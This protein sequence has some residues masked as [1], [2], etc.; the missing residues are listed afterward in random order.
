[1]T[2]SARTPSVS[3]Q[4]FGKLADGRPA[5]LYTLTN[6]HGLRADITN[7][8][9]ILVRLLTPDRH[10]QLA[11]VVLGYNSVEEYERSNPYFGAL[12]GRVGNRTAH[13][14][15]TLDGKTYT[16][17]TNNEPAG[18]PCHL[19]GGKVGFDK[20]LWQGEPATTADGAA[21]TLRYVSADGEEGYP[22]RLDVTVVYTL[23]NDDA[24]RI[25]YRA[26]TDRATPVSLTH[27]SYFN[28]RGEGSGDIL[29]HELVL[30]AARFTPVTA[31][32]VPT[33]AIAPVAGTPF[34]FTQA[35]RMG[36]RVD[37]A[38]EQLK[39]AGGYDHNWVL[40]SA[41]GKLALAAIASEPSTGRVLEVW[42]EE[43]GIQFYCGNF[44]DGSAIGKSGRAY[45]F[46][47]GFCLETQHFP[48][49]ANQPK[50]PSIILR[51]GETYHTRTE[52]RFA[53]G[54]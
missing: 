47:S 23:T 7:Y 19:H 2:S 21:L 18:I 51:P 10:G 32:L 12:I 44:L 13:G 34:D 40:D 53:V 50:F 9:G 36:E 11:D 24:L 22:G 3:S 54:K 15:F 41:A 35:H 28:L 5:T 43:P 27:H 26:T 20:V 49:S 52:Y 42:T 4:P 6:S 31:G 17:A 33:G 48:D 29:G 1:M 8:G 38:E 25:D 14:K 46:R 45:A 30:R 16:L 39:L 37:A